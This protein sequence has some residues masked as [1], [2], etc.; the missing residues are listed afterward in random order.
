MYTNVIEYRNSVILV[1][2]GDFNS[3]IVYLEKFFGPNTFYNIASGQGTLKF[4]EYEFKWTSREKNVLLW[5]TLKWGAL[6]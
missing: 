3:L 2:E 5:D 1:Y 4:G 6:K